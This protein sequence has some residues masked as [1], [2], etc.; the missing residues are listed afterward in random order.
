MV[1]AMSDQQAAGAKAAAVYNAASDH[2]TAAPLGFWDRYG[3]ETVRRIGLSAGAH[4]LDLCCGAGA[5]ALEAARVVGPTG[6]VI[7]VDLA[8]RL[9][10]IAALQAQREGLHNVEFRWADAT[11]TGLPSCSFDTVVCVFGVFF[12]SDRPGF[13]REMWRQLRPGGTLAVTVWG[14][15]LFEPAISVFWQ[16][17]AKSRPD[18]VRAF[19]PWDDLT[20]PDAV[21]G[22]LRDAGVVDGTVVAES[23][24]HPINSP[25]DFWEIVL[26]TGYRATVDAM[27]PQ[28]AAELRRAVLEELRCRDVRTLTTNVLYATAIRS[29]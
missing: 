22:L 9:L 8:Q 23:G 29:H 18:L 26:G 25:D 20:T 13:V 10:D 28:D 1:G 12:A 24:L 17:V 2:F 19:N 11:A 15:N 21:T 6:Q 3:A 5:S 16:E 4:V 7:G 14:P 27:S